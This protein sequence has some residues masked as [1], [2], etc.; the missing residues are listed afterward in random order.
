MERDGVVRD[1]AGLVV[2]VA[3]VIEGGLVASAAGVVVVVGVI[4][5]GG[6]VVV[7]VAVVV[8]LVD[9]G[10]VVVIV[11]LVDRRVVVVIV[12]G[13]AVIAMRKDDRSVGAVRVIAAVMG[14]VQ[15]RQH[16]HA[17]EPQQARHQRERAPVPVLM[18]PLH[19]QLYYESAPR[20]D[21]PTGLGRRALYKERRAA[22]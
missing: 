19:G 2:R 18:P 22:S 6:R 15:V 12:I 20:L 3:R 1:A 16:L 5:V 7:R 13:V 4:G 8:V 21:R 17:E 14:E 10:V 11:V 9:R